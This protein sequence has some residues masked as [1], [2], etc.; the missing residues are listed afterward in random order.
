MDADFNNPCAYAE[1]YQDDD[2]DDDYLDEM[3][4][5]YEEKTCKKE[6]VEY[7]MTEEDKIFY[8]LNFRRK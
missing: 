3:L 5:D 1:T 8:R 2:I 4:A 7:Y 6:P